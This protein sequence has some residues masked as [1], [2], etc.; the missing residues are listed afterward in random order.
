[1][2]FT[3]FLL[4]SNGEG[5]ILKGF[6]F[7]ATKFKIKKINLEKQ[8]TRQADGHQKMEQKQKNV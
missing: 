4:N 8:V 5:A 3:I 7:Y 2:K 1:M 6:F